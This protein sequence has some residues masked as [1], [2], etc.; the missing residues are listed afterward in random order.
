[1][2]KPIKPVKSRFAY[3]IKRS[4]FGVFIGLIMSCDF[5]DNSSENRDNSTVM[6]REEPFNSTK[7]PSARLFTMTN[8]NGMSVSVTNYGG[9]IT[10]ILFNDAAG[11]KKDLVLGFDNLESYQGEHPYF[12]A[13]VGRYANRIARGRFFIDSDSYDLAVNNGVNALHGGIRGFDKRIWD[14]MILDSVH[15]KGIEI[16]GISPHM[17]E[18]YPGNLKF[19]VRYLLNDDNELHIEYEATTDQATVLNLTNHSYFNLNGAGEGDVLDHKVMINADR[20]TPV[21]EKLIPTGELR[22][23]DSTPFD[24]REWRRI[25]ESIK[26]FNNEQIKYGGG[27]DHNFVLT[28]SNTEKLPLSASAI[29]NKSKILLEVFSSEPGIQFYTGNFLDGNIV[30]KNDKKYFK[31]AAFCFETQHFPDSPNQPSFPSTRL[32]PG[33]TYRSKTIYKFSLYDN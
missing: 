17:D 8:D 4:V 11:E 27:Y 12:G 3:I 6:I 5:T 13:F 20:Y 25:G 24:F 15:V 9:I 18:G 1:M 29:G 31:H 26:D 22:P 28:G 14:A 32:N 10:S 23:V 16:S 21:D 30:G 7:G 19:K 2:V 33:D